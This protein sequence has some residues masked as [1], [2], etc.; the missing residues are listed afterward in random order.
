MGIHAIPVG[1]ILATSLLGLGGIRLNL[2]VAEVVVA[3]GLLVAVVLGILK[4][5]PPPAAL[6]A[7]GQTFAVK[8]GEGLQARH[9][10]RYGKIAVADG[11]RV[12]RVDLL[13]VGVVSL[14]KGYAVN[15]FG[16]GAAGQKEDGCEE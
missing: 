16:C 5:M 3:K 14:Q 7:E 2:A 4:G 1:S 6:C 11:E 9:I 15:L 12:E 8:F 13:Q 10:D